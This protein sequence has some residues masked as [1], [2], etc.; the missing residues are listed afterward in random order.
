MSRGIAFS[1]EQE[2]WLED[3]Y[4]NLGPTKATPLFNTIFGTNR[5][6]DT[7]RTHC[8]RKG[9]KCTKDVMSRRGR[10][11][12]KRYIDVGTI[13]EDSHGY[14]HIKIDNQKNNRNGNYK[15][16]HRY[17]WEKVNGKIPDD[18]YLIFLDGNK[19]NCEL[20]NLCLIPKSFI[21]ILMK[22][23]LRSED[24]ELTLTAVEWCKLYQALKEREVVMSEQEL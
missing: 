1:Q 5:S 13:V 20:S 3:N 23:N 9:L 22:N 2:K 19:K 12:A 16:L 10:E 15:L 4:C 6:Y 24:K 8:K 18:C 11:N 21:A 17:T 14:L 7:I